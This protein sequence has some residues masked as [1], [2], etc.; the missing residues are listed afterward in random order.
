MHEEQEDAAQK[1]Q[2]RIEKELKLQEEV[3]E[4]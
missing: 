1:E 4:L 3:L 2:H